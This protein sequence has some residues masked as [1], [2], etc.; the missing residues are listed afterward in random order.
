MSIDASLSDELIHMLITM[1]GVTAVNGKF[2][3]ENVYIQKT[4]I[5]NK[6]VHYFG[7]IYINK[8]LGKEQAFSPIKHA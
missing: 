8:N 2:V 1:C 4:A 6:E 5:M 7:R 3:S